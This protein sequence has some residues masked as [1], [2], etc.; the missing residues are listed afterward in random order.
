LLLF[1][2]E[3]AVLNGFGWKK[4]LGTLGVKKFLYDVLFLSQLE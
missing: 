4:G 1:A 2:I 3:M